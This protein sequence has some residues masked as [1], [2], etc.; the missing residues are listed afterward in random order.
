MGRGQEALRLAPG[1][2]ILISTE[3]PQATLAGVGEYVEFLP[4]TGEIFLV[5]NTKK[6]N[7]YLKKNDIKGISGR[8]E[9]KR[10]LEPFTC[11]IG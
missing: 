5:F 9:I 6:G 1:N 11:E 4:H 3:E 10:F 8:G 7:V 2:Q